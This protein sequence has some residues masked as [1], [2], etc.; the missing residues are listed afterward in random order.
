MLSDLARRNDA[1][2][3]QA[4]ESYRMQQDQVKSLG[5]SKLN[6]MREQETEAA[7]N[8]QAKAS[9]GNA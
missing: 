5:D 3:K 9:K 2:L 4:Q 6:K 7:A 8:I 1:Q